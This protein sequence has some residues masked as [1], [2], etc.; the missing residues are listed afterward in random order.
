MTVVTTRL[1]VYDLAEQRTLT[2]TAAAMHEQ[3]RER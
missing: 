3:E 2:E 1:S